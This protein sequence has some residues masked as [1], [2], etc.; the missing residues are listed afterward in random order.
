MSLNQRLVT[1]LI[2]K[3]GNPAPFGPILPGE[4]RT[5]PHGLHESVLG[6]VAPTIVFPDCITP[7]VVTAA[8]KFTI[9]IF[10]PDLVSSHEVFFRCERKHTIEETP[11]LLVDMLWQGDCGFGVT[12]PTGPTGPTGTTGSTG[13][14][15]TGPTGS[16]GPGGPSGGPTGATGATS[17]VTGP[18]GPT[19]NTGPT[20]STGPTGATG[21]TG[22]GTG[23]LAFQSMATPAAA[24]FLAAWSGSA[25]LAGA[26]V[27]TAPGGVT[28]AVFTVRKNG[29]NTALV[30]T[31]SG[32]AT[33]GSDLVN[34]VSVSPGD[35]ITVQF[36]KIGLPVATGK[37]TMSME[38]V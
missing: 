9:T 4:T 35:T 17:T 2:F 28:A 33:T 14:G 24:D 18:T 23:I 16:T 10:N 8:D 19:G 34:S 7:L 25:T 6:P 37:L 22:P 21:P 3:A 5:V 31:I 1:D 11:G 29:V 38:L 13:P 27:T 30:V 20:G 26:L 15:I 12:G 32:A 36:T